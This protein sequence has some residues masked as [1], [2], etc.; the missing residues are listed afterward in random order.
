MALQA[1]RDIQG[2]VIG[3]P[4]GSAAAVEWEPGNSIIQ[5]ND[6]RAVGYYVSAV[7]ANITLQPQGRLS[8]GGVTGAW[9]NLGSAVTGTAGTPA[10]A[11]LAGNTGFEAYNEFRFLWNATSGGATS[12]VGITVRRS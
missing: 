8:V 2:I 5:C 9:V 12:A 4:P 6:V 11:M 3:T 10:A 7:S 1:I